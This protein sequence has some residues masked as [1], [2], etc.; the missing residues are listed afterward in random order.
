[1]SAGAGKIRG[2]WTFSSNFRLLDDRFNP[3]DVG[4]LRRANFFR[5]GGN[6]EHKLKG[7]KSFGAFQHA[8]ARLFVGHSWS[9]RKRLSQGFGL[10]FHTD[11]RTQSFQSI[12]LRS[13]TDYLFGGYDLYETR[14][15]GPRARPR[16]FNV[17]LE[18]ETDSRRT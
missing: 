6:V 3:N 14:G 9:Y 17:N 18:F 12:R 7:G 5:L 1:M 16:V 4:R 8:S 11:W 13:G 15:L 2:P 10:S